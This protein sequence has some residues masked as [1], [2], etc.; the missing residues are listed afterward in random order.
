MGVSTGVQEKFG[1]VICSN[2]YSFVV[3]VT[4]LLSSQFTEPVVLRVGAGLA[5]LGSDSGNDERHIEEV[6]GFAGK[7]KVRWDWGVFALKGSE[8]H[9]R[10]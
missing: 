10:P 7:V 8:S 2:A 5:R 1:G 4:Q 3:L 9:R 6:V